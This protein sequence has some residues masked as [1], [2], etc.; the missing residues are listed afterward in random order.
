M[1]FAFATCDRKRALGFLKSLYPSRII[2]D[3]P[4]SAGPL[5]DLV[6][7]DIIRICDPGFHGGQ[8]IIGTNWD[9]SRS[10]E[11]QSVCQKFHDAEEVPHD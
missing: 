8:V 7:L 5:L 1:A 4:E 10:A 11:V 3:T 9:E 2:Q 6:Q